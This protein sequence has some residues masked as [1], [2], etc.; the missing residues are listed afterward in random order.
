MSTAAVAGAAGGGLTVAVAEGAAASPALAQATLAAGCFWCSSGILEDLKGV[1]A[2]ECGYIGGRPSNPTYRQ[3]CSGS[4]GHAEAVRVTF[5]PAVL[6]FDTLLHVFFTLHDPTQKDRQGNNVGTQYRSAIF[7]HTPEQLAA[8]R[9]HMAGIQGQFSAPL[10]TE[11]TDATQHQWWVAE[12][13]HQSYCKSDEGSSNP[14]VH[15]VSLPKARKVKAK[16][17][18]L[19]K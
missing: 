15:G 9:A 4:T 2:A 5:D 17:P 1:S 7:Y 11:L 8:S 19:F 3:V 16:L 14:Y 6:P 10:A 12:D 18:H 13:Y